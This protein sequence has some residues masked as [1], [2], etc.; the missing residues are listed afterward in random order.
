MKNLHI[1]A[2]VAIPLLL[3]S[4][5][6][7]SA[8]VTPAAQCGTPPPGVEVVSIGRALADNALGETIT[9]AVSMA[10]DLGGP[11]GRRFT[12][13]V[14]A[15]LVDS[16]TTGLWAVSYDPD[17]LLI[18]VDPLNDAATASMPW[19]SSRLGSRGIEAIQA[20]LASRQATELLS[21]LDGGRPPTAVA[22]PSDDS[23]LGETIAARTC[24]DVQAD[25]RTATRR[26]SMKAL[27]RLEQEGKSLGCEL[28]GGDPVSVLATRNGISYWW[29]AT[30]PCDGTTCFAMTIR[31]EAQPCP[32]G[33]YVEINLLDANGTVVGYSNDIVGALAVG[34]EARVEFTATEEGVTSAVVNQMSCN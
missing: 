33:V 22:S 10:V 25:Y 13:L 28:T 14:A 19:L 15:H 5:G 1:A 18:A 24:F 29:S 7:G 8:P 2:L 23:P 20:A 26:S 30:Q 11:A 27:A 31:A 17:G 4:C 6:T 21:C 3:A 12:S 16:D 32:N 9:G 34:Q